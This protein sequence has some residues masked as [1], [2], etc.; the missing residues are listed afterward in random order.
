MKP[1]IQ[2][3]NVWFD[4][5]SEQ[6][7]RD[8]WTLQNIQL[9]IYLSEFVSIVGPNGSGKSTLAKLFNGLILPMEGALTVAGIDT[10]EE[11]ERWRIRSRVGMVFQNPDNQIV[12][13]TVEDDIAFGLEN[14]GIPRAEMKER[15]DKALWL[16]GL[17]GLEKQEPH[18]LSGG[19][20]QRLAIAG[21][22]A[23]E[24]DVII[25]DE[26][27]SMLDPLGKKEVLE[28]I[29]K[30]HRDEKKTI[31]QV[32]HKA[33]EAFLGERI[34]V[35]EA[36]SIRLDQAND[37]LYPQSMRLKEWGLDVPLAVE[38]HHRLRLQ[39][40]PL[41]ETISSEEELVHA[42]WTLLPNK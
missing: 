4:Y 11:A 37:D 1:I 25:L 7:P 13:G 16:A 36:G 29:R 41:P 20:K 42:L 38:L 32:T 24:P 40:L 8:R 17:E 33:A 26:A 2:A 10:R 18:S 9:S 3:K 23:M 34:I 5:D 35:M 19:Q 14:L 12:A 15:I 39:G 6:T 22:L 30:L 21:V 27:T 31:I 28:L